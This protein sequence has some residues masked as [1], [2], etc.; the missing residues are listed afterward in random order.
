MT[1]EEYEDQS[2][3]DYGKL[4]LV[5][6]SNCTDFFKEHSCDILFADS[7]DE[8]I[9]KYRERYSPG[10]PITSIPCIGNMKW[11]IGEEEKYYFQ[12]Y[13]TEFHIFLF[14][15]C[16]CHGSIVYYYMA[17]VLIPKCMYDYD[18]EREEVFRLA[19]IMYM[20]YI[21]DLDW[22][23]VH[24]DYYVTC[25]FTQIHRVRIFYNDLGNHSII[26]SWKIQPKLLTYTPYSE[27]SIQIEGV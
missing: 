3:I 7:M 13:P 4:Y 17:A 8:S 24:P 26:K 27:I 2:I 12:L 5:G 9:K 20:E 16:A 23:G 1:L 6:E 10:M 19:Q 18:K 11:K 21:K 15:I 22:K 14:A 25:E